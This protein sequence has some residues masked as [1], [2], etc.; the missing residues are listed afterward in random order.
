[1]ARSQIQA[2]AA[3]HAKGD[4]AEQV[5]VGRKRAV[6]QVSTTSNPARSTSRRE[7][8]WSYSA[9]CCGAWRPGQ[10]LPNSRND[11][12]SSRG[13]SMMSLPP[14]LSAVARVRERP[15]RV[16]VVLEEVPHRDQVEA[17]VARPAARRTAPWWNS[18]PS[19]SGR[20]DRSTKSTP[21][22]VAPVVR[23][24]RCEERAGPAADV[25]HR[26]RG[27]RGSMYRRHDA[28]LG[29]IER[30]HRRTRTAAPAGPSAGCSWCAMYS[31]VVVRP[32]VLERQPRLLIDEAA[33]DAAHER[34]PSGLA[35][36]GRLRPR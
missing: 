24:R 29:A 21:A 14:G 4:A 8:G 17:V 22:T 35:P 20:A 3:Q 31:V 10:R 25:E 19:N 32:D 1:M 28:Q 5:E 9:V 34:E 6:R 33:V 7:R 27:R 2:A 13:T 36:S 18:T 12:L 16:V 23:R 15:A 11:R 30:A 26:R